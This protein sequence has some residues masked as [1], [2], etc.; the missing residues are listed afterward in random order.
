MSD[1]YKCKGSLL[2]IKS[3]FNHSSTD[4]HYSE[5]IKFSYDRN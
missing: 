4:S 1:M 5:M 3:P 2:L